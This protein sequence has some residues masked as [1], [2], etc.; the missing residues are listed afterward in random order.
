MGQSFSPTNQQKQVMTLS[1]LCSSAANNIWDNS[2]LQSNIDKYQS[3]IGAWDVVWGPYYYIPNYN[4]N[5]QSVSANTMFIAQNGSSYVIAIAPT[6]EASSYDWLSEDWPTEATP[7]PYKEGA[8]N[9]TSGDLTGLNVLLNQLSTPGAAPT[10]VQQP[11]TFLA[12]L[13][14]KSTIN[15]TITGHSLG[16]A[17]APL[18]ALALMDPQSSL[19]TSGPDV[20]AGNWQQ[21]YVLATAGPSPCDL[22]LVNYFNQTVTTANQNNSSQW[23]NDFIWNAQDI[24]PQAWNEQTLQTLPQFYNLSLDTNGCLYKAMQNAQNKVQGLNYTQFQPTASFSGPLQ[25]YTGSGWDASPA[26][27]KFLAQAIYQHVNAYIA[28]FDCP[29]VPLKSDY[30]T[31]AAQ[32]DKI[33]TVFCGAAEIHG[34]C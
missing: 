7:W 19:N 5:S 8:G 12:G 3:D 4:P 31:D 1:W 10:Q 11:Q 18:F 9:V 17:L 22:T 28:A 14:N 16:G 24:V 27:S 33:L 23:T 21:V 20:S 29:W 6:N 2:T 32:A 34:I 30:C 15:L 13:S 26:G 25:P